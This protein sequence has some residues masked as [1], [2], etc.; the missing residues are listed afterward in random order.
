MAGVARVDDANRFLAETFIADYN[1]RF[2]VAPE[3][4]GSAFV[5][6]EAA[7]WRDVLCVQ[8]DRTVSADNTVHRCSPSEIHAPSPDVRGNASP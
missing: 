6:V 2:A 1:E 3:E 4:P 7:Q 5:A 8:E